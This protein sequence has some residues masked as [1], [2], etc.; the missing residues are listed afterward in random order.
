M[1]W[2]QKLL[3]LTRFLEL[4]SILQGKGD[5]STYWL[6]GQD[7]PPA[8]KKS[9]YKKK[10]NLNYSKSCSTNSIQDLDFYFRSN[11]KIHSRR[12]SYRRSGS[13]F[14][15]YQNNLGKKHALK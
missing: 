2:V 6:I 1:K 8:K 15:E 14:E 3:S 7:L 11:L 5:M 4:H 13:L 10:N 9:L 12:G